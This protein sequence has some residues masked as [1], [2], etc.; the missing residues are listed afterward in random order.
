M[1]VLAAGEGFEQARIV[2]QVRHDAQLDLR[3][4]G[5]GDTATGR[6]DEGRADAP[7]FG[8][9]HGNVLQVGLGRCQPAGDGDG[10][11]EAGMDAAGRG[12]DH[13]RQLVGVGVLELG[14]AAVVE[15]Q[16]RQRVVEGELLQHL[17]VGRRRL[18]R[19]A[20]DHRQAL[21][22][23]QDL[24]EL[25]GRVEVEGLARRLV[26]ARFEFEHAAAELVALPRQRRA[27]DQHAVALHAVEH[28]GHRQ[29]D[30]AVEAFELFLRRQ[31]RRQRLMHAQRDV[32]IL[33]GVFG[34][35]LDGDLGEADARGALAGDLVVA[36]G[37]QPGVARWPARRGRAT[38]RTPARRTR[39]GCRP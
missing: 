10:L 16:P 23:E 18:G 32:G 31:P 9:A 6:R 14:D 26:G 2:R 24:A 39:A 8:G 4:V 7:A 20:L 12:I 35:A 19:R 37:V 29:F 22:L 25:L 34:G 21:A 30:V 36:D 3:I 28:L 13:L 33:G 5:A 1:H 27:V 11:R 15:D 17:L 38:C